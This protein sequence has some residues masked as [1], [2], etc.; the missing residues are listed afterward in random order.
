MNSS[1]DREPFMPIQ[2]K[3]SKLEK[4]GLG[5]PIMKE[6]F[7]IGFKKQFGAEFK[8]LLTDACL[9]CEVKKLVYVKNMPISE[10]TST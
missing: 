9:D 1:P 7:L 5:D 8:R 4:E 2:E 6:E 10:C 3:I